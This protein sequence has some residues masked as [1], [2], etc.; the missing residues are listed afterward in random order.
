MVI[1]NKDGSVYRLSSPNPLVKNQ[2]KWEKNNIILHNLNW[3]QKI[4]E[5]N[6]PEEII[7]EEKKEE[8]KKEEIKPKE[9]KP[10]LKNVVLMHCLPAIIKITKDDLYNETRSKI[11]YGEKFTFEGVVI[12]RGDFSIQFWTNIDLAKNSI[13]YPTKYRDGTPFGDFR[14]WSVNEIKDKSDGK[15]ITAVISGYQPHFKEN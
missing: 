1:K 8:I 12:E 7:I 15:L 11:N 3:E 13:I 6:E 10:E 9:N 14:W 4:I 2:E 5:L